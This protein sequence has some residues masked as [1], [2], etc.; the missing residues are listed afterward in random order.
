MVVKKGIIERHGI[1]KSQHVVFE[2]LIYQPSKKTQ[3]LCPFFFLR[4]LNNWVFF[5][6]DWKKKQPL[7]VGKF[8]SR[9]ITSII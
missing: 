4:D 8:K 9:E 6:N 3:L 5:L 1:M 7:S 2:Q